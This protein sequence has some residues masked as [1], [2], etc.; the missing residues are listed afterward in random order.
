MN[1]L[2]TDWSGRHLLRP[3]NRAVQIAV[4]PASERAPERPNPRLAIRNILSKR[5]S[6]LRIEFRPTGKH[7]QSQRFS[8]LLLR[9]F[10]GE[11]EHILHIVL[12]DQFRESSKRVVEPR[13]SIRFKNALD[14]GV[15]ISLLT[16]RIRRPVVAANTRG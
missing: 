15:N 12:V 14:L 7:E 2:I 13:G 6:R 11:G 3:G 8:L 10:F 1:R 9:D 5:K 16:V 4:G